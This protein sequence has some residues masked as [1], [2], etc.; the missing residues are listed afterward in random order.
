MTG[1][2]WLYHLFAVLM[3]VVAAYC[4]VL[5]VFSIK[6][7]RMSGWDVDVAHVLMGTGMAG[8]FI[9]ELAFGPTWAWELAFF[10]LMV[11][12]VARSIQSVQEFG[13]HLPHYVIHAV[14]SLAMLLMFAFPGEANRLSAPS[15]A[16]SSSAGSRL[17][18]GLGFLLAFTFFASAIFTLASPRKGAA[19][20]GSHV[21]DYAL[22]GSVE[23]DRSDG[24]ST[25]TVTV[26]NVSMIERVVATPWLEDASHVVMCVAMG[27]MLILMI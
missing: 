21:P 18:P 8:M 10:V 11:W 6:E 1:P 14:M 3:L 13:I 7:R 24:T 2:S 23:P 9:T 22:V 12:F 4:L 25:V 17:D 15:M 5:L 19:H 16:M 27:L 20:H 26:T